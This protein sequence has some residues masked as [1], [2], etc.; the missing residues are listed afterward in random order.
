MYGGDGIRPDVV[1]PE[2]QPRPL[3]LARVHEQDL[4]LRWVADYL[5]RTPDLPDLE[6]L[7]EWPVL[8]DTGVADFRTFAA[9]QG[10]EIPNDAG[11]AAQLQ[12]VLVATV[13]MARW[14][15]PGFYRIAAL[16]DPAVEAAAD[17][18]DHAALILGRKP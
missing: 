7:A 3:W 13:A 12:G 2:P 5:H 8:R 4:P 11:A 9:R 18:F 10:V 15:R 6:R 16:L 17:A 1:L 14:G